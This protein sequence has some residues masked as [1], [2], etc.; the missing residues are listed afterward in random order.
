VVGCYNN[1]GLALGKQA[2]SYPGPGRSETPDRVW[3]IMLAMWGPSMVRYHQTGEKYRRV[4][5]NRSTTGGNTTELL[6]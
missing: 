1:R 6:L 4:Q 2:K 5:S 3:V